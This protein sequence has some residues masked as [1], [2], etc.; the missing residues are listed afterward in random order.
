MKPLLD[1]FW[2]ALAYS[3]HPRVLALSLLPW[4]VVGVI[5]LG[6][7]YLFW[8]AMVHAVR[9]YLESWALVESFLQ[10]M[11]RF[12]GSDFRT[13]FV[14]MIV[15]ALEIPLI[16]AAVLVLVGVWTTPVVVSMVARRRFPGL[17]R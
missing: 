6:V 15:V 9:A 3:L 7:N 17:E 11:T 13:V 8:E 1:S 10:W 2:R 16:V 4:L 12:F 5:T 14:L